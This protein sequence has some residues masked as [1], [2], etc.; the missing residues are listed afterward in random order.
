MI[1]QGQKIW[2]G[3]GQFFVARAGPGRV[4]QFMVWVWI[5]KISPKMSNFAIFS[6]SDQK[7]FLQDGLKSTRVEGGSASHLLRVKSKLGSGQGPSLSYAN[8]KLS[9]QKFF[10]PVFSE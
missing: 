10:Y 5:W 6:P 3:L 9:K 8:F 4:S 7:K 2:P 1:G